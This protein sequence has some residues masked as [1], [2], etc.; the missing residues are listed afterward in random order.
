MVALPRLRRSWE[1]LLSFGAHPGE[2]ETQRG[3]RR[4]IVGAYWIGTTT[5][6]ASV[7]IDFGA[8]SFLV[9]ILDLV[10]VVLGYAS[11][12]ALRL[13]PRRFALIVHA[14]LRRLWVPHIAPGVG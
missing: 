4:I 6:I 10:T 7:L 12:I 2:T 14:S 11:L 3:R 5:A 13:R 9:G 1:Y 8:G